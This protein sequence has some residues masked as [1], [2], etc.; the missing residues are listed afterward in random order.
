[1]RGGCNGGYPYEVDCVSC[2]TGKTSHIDA[3][4]EKD[5]YIPA[6]PKNPDNNGKC[7]DDEMKYGDQC[8]EKIKE[9]NDGT[10]YILV[11]D[12]YY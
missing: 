9:G 5:C 1:M 10:E 12:C 7:K 6:N 11:G 4:S 8:Y 2:P 3:K